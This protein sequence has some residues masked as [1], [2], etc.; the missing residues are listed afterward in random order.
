MMKLGLTGAV[1]GASLCVQ[2]CEIAEAKEKHDPQVF[3]EAEL[4]KLKLVDF[5]AQVEANYTDANL[6]EQAIILSSR[7]EFCGAV[8][9]WTVN[10]MSEVMHPM[11]ESRVFDHG[12]NHW[13]N[14][15]PEGVGVGPLFEDVVVATITKGCLTEDERRG[16]FNDYKARILSFYVSDIKIAMKIIHLYESDAIRDDEY[17]MAQVKGGQRYISIL[18]SRYDHDKNIRYE[19][20]F[21]V[22]SN[23]VQIPRTEN[24]RYRGA[25]TLVANLEKKQNDGDMKQVADAIETVSQNLQKYWELYESKTIEESEKAD[26]LQAFMLLQEYQIKLMDAMI[27]HTGSIISDTIIESDDVA[28]G[29]TEFDVTMRDTHA[30]R[31]EVP[32]MNLENDVMVYRHAGAINDNAWLRFAEFN[33]F[34]NAIADFMNNTDETVSDSIVHW[35]QSLSKARDN[36]ATLPIDVQSDVHLSDPFHQ[37]LS[38][39]IYTRLSPLHASSTDGDWVLLNDMNW[40]YVQWWDERSG[41]SYPTSSAEVHTRYGDICNTGYYSSPSRLQLACVLGLMDNVDHIAEGFGI[42]TVQGAERIQELGGH[43]TDVPA[44]FIRLVAREHIADKIDGK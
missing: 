24:R 18:K 21:E 17:A 7:R 30:R 19:D 38:N 26:V 29:E 4:V 37:I 35:E 32:E 40:T 27:P 3:D 28:K 23:K 16:F 6:T 5:L 9:D 12:F 20:I 13:I 42:Q 34:G 44:A 2:D 39:D 1:L 25:V 15:L 11:L 43:S 33:Y 14:Q 31:F 10:Y 36:F 41:Y 8:R 22:D